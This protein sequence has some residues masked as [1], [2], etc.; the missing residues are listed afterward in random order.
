MKFKL[1]EQI[2]FL[3]TQDIAFPGTWLT[4]LLYKKIIF[5]RKYYMS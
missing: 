3:F 5:K 4:I 2:K 1:E